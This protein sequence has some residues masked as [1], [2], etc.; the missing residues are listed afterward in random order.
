[1]MEVPLN[2]V[3]DVRE[4]ELYDLIKNEKWSV[5]KDEGMSQLLLSDLLARDIGGS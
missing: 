5:R 1:M 3:E 2:N 4:P